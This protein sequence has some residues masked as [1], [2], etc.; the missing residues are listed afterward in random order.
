ME[1]KNNKLVNNGFIIPYLQKDNIS[2]KPKEFNAGVN[3]KVRNVAC[4]SKDY[5]FSDG[6]TYIFMCKKSK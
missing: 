6:I 1:E 5:D 3:I 2:K 4:L